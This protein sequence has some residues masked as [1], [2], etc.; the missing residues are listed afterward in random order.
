MR[1]TIGFDNGVSGSVGIIED[2]GA[3]IKSAFIP[4]PVI[5]CLSYTKEPQHIHRIDWRALLENLPKTNAIAFVERPLVNPRMF[6][7]T[8]S[9]M[10]ALEAT[11]IVLEMLDIPYSYVDS[12]TWQQEFIASGVI[13]HDDMKKASMEVGLQLFP[14]NGAFI[15]KHGDAD[16]L[17]IAEWGRRK[18]G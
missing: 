1:I 7:A 5:K 15:K 17:L 11:I 18:G 13:G 12:K 8:Q 14:S 2:N 6:K 9:A 4:T 16:G 3:S 10:R